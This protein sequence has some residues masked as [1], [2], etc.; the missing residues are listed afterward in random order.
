M[1]V[2]GG[3]QLTGACDVVGASAF[4]KQAVM[5]DAV[6]AGWQRVDEEAADELAGGQGQPHYKPKPIRNTILF[7]ADRTG[8]CFVFRLRRR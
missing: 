4:G 6:E 5:A 3:E 2:S 7:P 1:N 8:A